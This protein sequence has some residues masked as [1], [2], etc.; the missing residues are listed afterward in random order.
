MNIL[1]CLELV[2]RRRRENFVFYRSLNL[3][4]FLHI[5]YLK[6][7]FKN[8]DLGKILSDDRDLGKKIPV[9]RSLGKIFNPI[10]LRKDTDSVQ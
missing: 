1:Y 9:D 5:F 8:W 3:S 10:G 2:A 6:L 4:Y 7:G